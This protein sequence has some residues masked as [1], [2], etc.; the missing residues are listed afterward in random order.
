MQARN[1][2]ADVEKEHMDQSG[3]VEGGMNWEIRI[4]IQRLPY[5]KC[6]AGGNCDV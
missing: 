3:E 6:I 1:R 5:V 4:D 2:N